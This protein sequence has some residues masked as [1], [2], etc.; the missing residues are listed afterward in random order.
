MATQRHRA[1]LCYAIVTQPAF[2]STLAV[3]S[4]VHF[5]TINNVLI[6]LLSQSPNIDSLVPRFTWHNTRFPTPAQPRH[7]SADQL[8][9]SCTQAPECECAQQTELEPGPDVSNRIHPGELGH[10]EIPSD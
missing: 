2:P 9:D 8:L 7:H 3:P 6:Y 10:K 1:C 4:A 5:P